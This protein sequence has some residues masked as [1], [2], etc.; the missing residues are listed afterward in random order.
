MQ[1]YKLYDYNVFEQ[2]ILAVSVARQLASLVK[3]I[4]MLPESVKTMGI[5]MKITFK[6]L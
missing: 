6:N 1:L 5:L 3:S 2:T 4:Y